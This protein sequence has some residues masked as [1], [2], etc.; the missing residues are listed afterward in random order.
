[1]QK[2]TTTATMHNTSISHMIYS[3]IPLSITFNIVFTL[4]DKTCQQFI[5]RYPREDLII[6][7]SVAIILKYLRCLERKLLYRPSASSLPINSIEHKTKT[8]GWKHV[9]ENYFMITHVLRIRKLLWNGV[10]FLLEATYPYVQ[11]N[12]G[13]DNPD[14]IW[15]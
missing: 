12:T 8:F 9:Y 3:A 6:Y 11:I 10:W 13:L 5:I 1:M 2:G 7:I 15:V 14:A 4:A